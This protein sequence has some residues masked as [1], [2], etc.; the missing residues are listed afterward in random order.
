MEEGFICSSFI[1]LDMIHLLPNT[2][3]QIVYLTLKEAVRDLSSFTNYL[4]EFENCTSREKYYIVADVTSENER[5]TKL[6]IGT[7]TD[8]A[9]V[10]LRVHGRL[11]E[12]RGSDID[13]HEIFSLLKSQGAYHVLRNTMKLTSAEFEEIKREIDSIEE[14]ERELIQEHSGQIGLPGTDKKEE[15]HI[16]EQILHMLNTTR[17]EGEKVASFDEKIKKEMDALLR[18]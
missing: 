13:F 4:V 10:L 7:D 5:Y 6:T 11:S 2:A 14:I 17:Q 16:T 12:G 8:D 1:F 18:L 3:S 9:I 15:M